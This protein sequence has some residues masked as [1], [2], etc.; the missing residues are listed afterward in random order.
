MKL[1]VTTIHKEGKKPISFK[2]GGLHEST[3]TPMGEKIP[4][5]KRRAA[6]AG[7]YGPK[8]KAQALFAKNVLH[9]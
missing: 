4:E 7:D 2:K 8:A 6:L 3:H 1:K 5:S 9:H